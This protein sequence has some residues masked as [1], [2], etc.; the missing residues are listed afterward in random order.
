MNLLLNFHLI[1]YLHAIARSRVMEGDEGWPLLPVIG[2]EHSGST[3]MLCRKSKTQICL[4]MLF[5]IF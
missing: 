1:C 3:V 2:S 4:V 5:L